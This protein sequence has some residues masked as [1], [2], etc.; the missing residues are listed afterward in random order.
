MLE[1]DGFQET[2]IDAEI[3]TSSCELG[4]LGDPADRILVATARRYDLVFVTRDSRILDYGAGGHV[5]VM[6]C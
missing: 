4:G 1:L 3:L 6:E 2:S 5:R